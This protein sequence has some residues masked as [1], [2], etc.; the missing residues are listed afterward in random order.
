M[1]AHSPEE[2]SVS[3]F[4][5]LRRP[6][7]AIGLRALALSFV[8]AGVSAH[9]QSTVPA[10]AAAKKVLSV[11]DY[12]RWRS[13][14]GAQISGDGRWVAYT[15]RYTNVA[16]ADAR[17]V[18]HI[19]R[20]DTNQDVQIPN[21]TSA[22]FSS[23]S[24]WVVYQ[25][26]SS[27]AARGGRG[28][29]GA[30]TAAAPGAGPPTVAPTPIPA[31]PAPAGSGAPG[32]GGDSSAVGPGGANGRAPS[33]LPAA[34]RRYELR[35]LATGKTQAW[36]DMQSAN[37]SPT[38]SHLI[39]R[40]RAQGAADAGGRGAGA[41]GAPGAT[42]AVTPA[43][44]APRGTDVVLHDLATGRSQLLGSV[45]D[46]AFNKKGDLL[47]YTVDAAIRDGNG[48]FLVD[49][50]AGRT[51]VL[52]NDARNYNRLTWNEDGSSIAVLK[53]READKMRER[54]NML[55]VFTDVRK[56]HGDMESAA[57]TLDPYRAKGFPRGWVV[58]DR[59]PITWSDDNKRVFFGVMP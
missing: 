45:G 39:L 46:I 36:A 16:V 30:P 42:T 44:N 54:D 33:P 29:G 10:G 35:E 13:I 37:F 1:S 17:P 7:V 28:R 12:A 41:G 47:A 51:E 15:L 57:T 27:A 38:A 2:L 48:V 21:A 20:L 24:R 56:A 43:P 19:L 25:I 55:I 11:N 32:P 52:D 58:S 5:K 18:L 26:D 22:S 4:G 31:A 49:V 59:A 53:G 50:L 9:A 40:R 8:L 23:D 14:D 34:P 6:R 3:S